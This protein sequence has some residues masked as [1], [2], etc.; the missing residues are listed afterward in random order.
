M[1]CP[2]FASSVAAQVDLATRFCASPNFILYCLWV[3][4]WGPAVGFNNRVLAL[5]L[6]NNLESK[7]LHG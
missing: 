2:M 1:H 5:R 7:T 3:C 6:Q 4:P